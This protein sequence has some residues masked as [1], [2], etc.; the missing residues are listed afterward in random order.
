MPASHLAATG[1]YL[2]VTISHHFHHFCVQFVLLHRHPDYSHVPEVLAALLEYDR[3]KGWVHEQLVEYGLQNLAHE[4]DYVWVTR[5]I[6]KFYMGL[7]KE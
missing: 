3:E 5:Q 4:T 1:V 6:I 2:V 7:L